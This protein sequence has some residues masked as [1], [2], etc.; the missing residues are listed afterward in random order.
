N[1]LKI[2]YQDIK[3]ASDEFI[4]HGGAPCR[5]YLVSGKFSN[6]GVILEEYVWAVNDKIYLL[7]YNSQSEGYEKLS[8]V[9]KKIFQSFRL[10]L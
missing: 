6:V 4:T 3:I 2:F 9:A 1:D 5:H 10:K 8:D 7:T